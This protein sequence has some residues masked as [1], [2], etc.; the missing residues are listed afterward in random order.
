MGPFIAEDRP[1]YVQ[2]EYRSVEDRNA[3]I[4]A[5]HYVGKDV[6][7][8]IITPGG[9]KDAIERVAS[10]WFEKLRRDV[11]NGRLPAQWLTAYENAF[12]AWESG[13]EIPLDGTPLAT[14]P[15]ITPSLLRTLLELRVKTVEDLAVANDDTINA[16]GMGGRAL[17]QQAIHWL[18]TAKDVGQTAAK[19]SALEAR[20]ADMEAQIAAERDKNTAL[21]RQLD[22]ARASQ[23]SPKAPAKFAA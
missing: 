15:P 19:L 11:E 5:G 13:Q 3:S 17:K 9:N 7:F 10:E 21:T 6:A 14:W 16:V 20:L 1:A 12:K 22:E 2:F 8:A 18:S 4:A 23:P